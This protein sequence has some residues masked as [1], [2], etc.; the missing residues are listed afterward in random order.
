M[1]G[2]ETTSFEIAIPAKTRGISSGIG[3]PIP[4]R[5]SIIRTDKYVPKPLSF[6]NQLKTSFSTMKNILKKEI[7]INIIN[8]KKMQR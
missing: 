8:T 1:Q 2:I 7:A 3:N 5:S 6:T 4:P